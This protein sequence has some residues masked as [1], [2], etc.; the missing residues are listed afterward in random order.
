MTGWGGS[1]FGGWISEIV[2]WKYFAGKQIFPFNVL[3]IRQSQK[4]GIEK[5]KIKRGL[6]HFLGEEEGPRGQIN[7]LALP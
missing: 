7:N 2:K 3:C 5:G 1:G 4:G 6:M